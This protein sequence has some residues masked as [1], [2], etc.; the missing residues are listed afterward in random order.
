MAFGHYIDIL[1]SI[2]SSG[3]MDII[4]FTKEISLLIHIKTIYQQDTFHQ[5]VFLKY[6]ILE[7]VYCKNNQKI[8]RIC[9]H[10]VIS[11]NFCIAITLNLF[12]LRFVQE[13]CFIYLFFGQLIGD[14]FSLQE[15]MLFQVQKE[16]WSINQLKYRKIHTFK[17]IWQGKLVFAEKENINYF[18][19]KNYHSQTSAGHEKKSLKVFF[20]LQVLYVSLEHRKVSQDFEPY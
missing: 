9:R 18:I 17:I 19:L 15:T 16:N 7:K 14:L 12:D 1:H 5:S 11:N 2:I 6:N 13:C 10:L 8:V 3:D 4:K 20:M